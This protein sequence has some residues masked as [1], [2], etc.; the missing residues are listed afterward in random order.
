[1]KNYLKK[2]KKNLIIYTLLIISLAGIHL[3]YAK[4]SGE[5]KFCDYAGVRR[6]FQ[7][8]GTIINIVEIVV[9]LIVIITG[10]VA[11][12]KGITSGKTEDLTGGVSAIVRK[13]IAGL[14]IFFIPNLIDYAFDALV[15]DR[16]TSSF[17]VCTSCFLNPDNCTIP[18]SD[19]VTYSND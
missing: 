10:M 14:L 1:M 9:P 2:N 5:V 16:D 18:E 4:T 11:F 6:T 13:I 17:A 15:D 12:F 19:P 3:V 7:I 8:L